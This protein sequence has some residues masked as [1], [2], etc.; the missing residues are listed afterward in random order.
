MSCSWLR[1]TVRTVAALRTT[2]MRRDVYPA[3][4]SSTSCASTT[5]YKT[6]STQPQYNPSAYN[7]SGQSQ[8][9]YSTG[10]RETQSYENSGWC[11]I[12]GQ[13]RRQAVYDFERQESSHDIPNSTASADQNFHSSTGQAVTHQSTQ[14]LK[15]LAHAPSLEAAGRQ[16]GSHAT[17]TAKS[18]STAVNA[19]RNTGATE[20]SLSSPA[21]A[22]PQSYSN[23]KPVSTSISHAHCQPGSSQQH[24]AAPA[25]LTL[26]G[27]I[28]RGKSNQQSPA[29]AH[30]QPP[31]STP[32]MGS[33]PSRDGRNPQ[34][35]NMTASPYVVSTGNPSRVT[36]QSAQH[37]R[38]PSLRKVSPQTQRYANTSGPDPSTM[39][40]TTKPQAH[41]RINDQVPPFWLNRS[42]VPTHT[43]QNYRNR[44]R[45]SLT[46]LAA[47]TASWN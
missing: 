43:A 32:S 38:A 44:N 24:P 23:Q 39:R 4:R 40:I 29:L 35:S 47:A 25:A 12:N 27:A 16:E 37:S 34:P 15:N 6:S 13:Q 17:R 2:K 8:R 10:N 5:E 26:A 28:S 21:Q 14:R 31:L 1:T 41:G 22:T 11:G 7:W 18:D 46:A 33:V 19:H 9:S 42:Y 3:A 30:R 20:T 36:Q 45:F